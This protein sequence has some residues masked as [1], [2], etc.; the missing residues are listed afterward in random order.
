MKSFVDMPVKL[1]DRQMMIF[2][3]LIMA[4]I[5]KLLVIESKLSIPRFRDGVDYSRRNAFPR[6]NNEVFRF[7]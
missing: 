3:K 6:K 2:D 7:Y 5:W 4:S 1:Q